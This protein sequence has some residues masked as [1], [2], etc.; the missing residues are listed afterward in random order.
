MN[1][2]PRSV[3]PAASVRLYGVGSSANPFN[4]QDANTNALGFWVNNPAASGDT[5]VIY[6]RLYVSG[7]GAGE[8]IRAYAT[9]NAANVATGGTINGLHA[10]LN[11]AASASV[12]GQGFASRHTIDAAAD[13]RT[14]SGNVA[15][16]LAESNFAAGNT[17][18]ATVALIQLGEI[19]AVTC[20][21]A[22]RLPNAANGGMLAAHTTQGMTHSIR[23]VSDNGTAYYIMCTNA[24]TNRS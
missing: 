21:T 16:I 22:F 24:A 20:K 9:A 12:S 3:R 2:I 18:P 11:I 17:V 19:G 10:S 8:A 1:K 4:I 7:A 6:A 14:I 15:A 13:T 23:I 5:R